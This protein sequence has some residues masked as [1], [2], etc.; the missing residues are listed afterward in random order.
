MAQHRRGRLLA[1]ESDVC[2]CVCA[3]TCRQRR[4][5]DLDCLF[6]SGDTHANL[7]IIDYPPGLVFVYKSQDCRSPSPCSICSLLYTIVSYIILFC[8]FFLYMSAR[9]CFLCA[10]E[11]VRGSSG[12]FHNDRHQMPGRPENAAGLSG[13]PSDLSVSRAIRRSGLQRFPRLPLRSSVHGLQTKR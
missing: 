1:I 13:F 7:S 5:R 11:T 4:R 9:S 12:V 10:H 2:V 6:A 3:P 8:S